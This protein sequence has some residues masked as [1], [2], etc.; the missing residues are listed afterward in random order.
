MTDASY[1]HAL[2]AGHVLHWYEV[3]RVLGEGGFGVTYLAYDRN[4]GIDVAIKEYLPNEL[5]VRLSDTSVQAKS[6]S[7][8]NDYESGLTRFIEEGQALAEFDHPN[9]VKVFTSF[10]AN[11]TAYLVMR[12]EEGE[13]L[14]RLLGRGVIFSE[15]E[16][17]KLLLPILD[18]LEGVHNKGWIHRDIKPSNIIIRADGSAV[19]TD[20][21][22]AR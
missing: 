4:L 6:S 22:S 16:I 9:I 17:K 3:K 18:G 14:S 11:G 12:Y 13:D 15:G 1:S 19:L 10:Q 7:Y 5:A 8:Q 20:F 21:G 2:R